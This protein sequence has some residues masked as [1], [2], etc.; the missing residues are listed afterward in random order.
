MVRAGMQKGAE[1]ASAVKLTT[2]VDA[3]PPTQYPSELSHP[4]L[5]ALTAKCR[6][7]YCLRFSVSP[8][9]HPYC[10]LL[11]GRILN[12]PEGIDGD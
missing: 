8:P 7:F 1:D 11:N 5:H 9:L 10:S 12:N 6:H 4:R 2:R 3:P